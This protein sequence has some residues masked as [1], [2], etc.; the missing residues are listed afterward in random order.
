M[1]CFAA[2]NGESGWS[3]VQSAQAAK[4]RKGGGTPA[5]GGAA[6]KRAPSAARSAGSKG[7]KAAPKGGKGDSKAP[8]HRRLA[9]PGASQPSRASTPSHDTITPIEVPERAGPTPTRSITQPVHRLPR[10]V[11]ETP[12]SP[13][14]REL[15]DA[16]ALQVTPAGPYEPWVVQLQNLG[17]KPV[18]L[19]SDV[20]LLWF[21]ATV[22]GKRSTVTCELPSSLRPKMAYAEE[23]VELEPGHELSF[24]IDPRFFCFENRD[25]TLLVPGTFLKPHYGWKTQ[26]ERTWQAG[27]AKEVRVEQTAPFVAMAS[28]SQVG[29]K[30]LLAPGIALDGRFAS[31][32]KTRI[33]AQ[34]KIPV[35]ADEDT[36]DSDTAPE[37]GEPLEAAANSGLELLMTR[38]SDAFSP[39]DIEIG[40]AVR[41]RGSEAQRVFLR[42]DQ[43]TFN[44]WGP[45][46]QV[47]CAPPFAYRA[48][49]AQGLTTLAPM[50][51]I[52]MTVRLGEFCPIGTFYRPGFYYIS[53]ALPVLDNHDDSGR[54]LPSAAV[55]PT[56][57]G[58]TMLQASYARP[59]RVRSSEFRFSYWDIS[60]ALTPEPQTPTADTTE[61][62][63]PGEATPPTP[64][65]SSTSH[66]YD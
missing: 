40:I 22:P 26:T 23:R 2:A 13:G 28:D 43:M 44:I 35:G 24:T 10:V 60:Q 27:K 55:N 66:K 18:K 4:G 46:G 50:K 63:A 41:N 15:T 47:Q 65:K 57:A 21:E 59:L 19:S 58:P 9:D 1:T 56:P 38:G 20:R 16:L 37:P 6:R 36:D 25:T 17:T 14:E 33:S 61:S 32:S 52:D 62:A 11:E 51:R 42:A 8:R 12:L 5:R 3:W 30:E 29:L 49:D 53:A 7:A 39:N 48:P 34:D 31:W 45:D 54:A 64:D